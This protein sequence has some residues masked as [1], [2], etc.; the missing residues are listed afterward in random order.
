MASEGEGRAVARVRSARAE[1]K[2]PRREVF[3]TQY[4]PR[5][6]LPWSRP[7]WLTPEGE[8]EVVAAIGRAERGHRGEIRVHLEAGTANERGDGA[9]ARARTL[10]AKLDL[11][12]TRDATG[13]L[14]YVAVEARTAAVFAGA[15]VLGGEDRA[16]WTHVVEAAARGFA[17]GDAPAGLCEAVELIGD[18]L[19]ERAP[20]DDDAGN[21]LS[22]E[23][24]MG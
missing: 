22:D 2:L 4:H 16:V 6:K 23:V 15:G 8:R 5:V 24:S 12:R 10:F 7:R 18:A 11:D 19:R 1:V 13:V 9:M 20:G 3:G 21:E 17:N 14:L